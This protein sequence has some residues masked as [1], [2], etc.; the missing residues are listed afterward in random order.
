MGPDGEWEPDAKDWV[1]WARTPDH[2]AY[3]YYRDIFLNELVPMPGR[4]AVEIGCGEGRVSRDLTAR[5]HRVVGVDTAAALLVYARQD[6]VANLA[7]ADGA[8]LPFADGSFDLVVAYNSLQVVADMPGTVRESARVLNTGGH[9]S[10]CVSHPMTDVGRFDGDGPEASFMVRDD[11]FY[12]R[13]VDDS[14]QR[15]GLKMRFRGWTHSL[16]DYLMALER[17]GLKLEALREPWPSDGAPGY[18]K[19]RKVPLF[20]M[21]RSVKG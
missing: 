13:R 20:L 15:N 17:A 7:R 5:G 14:V 19:W 2:D 1:R 6:G 10:F 21:A 18:D 9:F 8:A 3:W 11:Y 12:N 4:S 16:E